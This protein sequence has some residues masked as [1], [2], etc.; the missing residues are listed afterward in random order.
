M[1]YTVQSSRI[2]RD[3]QNNSRGVGFARLVIDFLP[4]L[5][6]TNNIVQI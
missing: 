5:L 2:L 4:E 6:D 3:S 1:D